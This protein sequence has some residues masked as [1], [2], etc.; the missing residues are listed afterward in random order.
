MYIPYFE[1]DKIELNE[2]STKKGLPY[3]KFYVT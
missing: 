3:K 1:E 2:F